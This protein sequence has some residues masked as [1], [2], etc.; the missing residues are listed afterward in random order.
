MFTVLFF[1][2]VRYLHYYYSPYLLFSFDP[3]CIIQQYIVLFFLQNSIITL[4]TS[5]GKVIK[6]YF[7][8]CIKT[9]YWKF[10]NF[11]RHGF[12]I[13]QFSFVSRMNS[14][15]IKYFIILLEFCNICSNL[16]LLQE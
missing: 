3:N 13:S 15:I 10:C 5:Y 14:H 7:F 16:V 4:I 2:M 6:I 9:F 8:F 1:I 12:S 11:S